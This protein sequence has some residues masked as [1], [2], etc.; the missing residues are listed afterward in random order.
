MDR[1]FTLGRAEFVEFD[2]V[3]RLDENDGC[4]SSCQ[5]GENA[6]KDVE[7]ELVPL[8]AHGDQLILEGAIIQ[9]E[10]IG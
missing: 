7:R 4:A 8:R 1:G 2:L 5:Y 9:L 3:E 6:E 10:P